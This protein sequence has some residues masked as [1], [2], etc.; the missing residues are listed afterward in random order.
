MLFSLSLPFLLSFQ[1]KTIVIGIVFLAS[2]IPVVIVKSIG[3]IFVWSHC[4]LW[5][6]LSWYLGHFQ[7][8]GGDQWCWEHH[9]RPDG[10]TC[11]GEISKVHAY[12][13]RENYPLLLSALWRNR[14]HQE[15]WDSARRISCQW[16][17]TYR[18]SIRYQSGLTS[19]TLTERS[20]IWRGN[21]C[22]RKRGAVPSLLHPWPSDLRPTDCASRTNWTAANW[23]IR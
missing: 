5:A 7:Q 13:E 20:N 6:Y 4:P 19:S 22:P 10:P 21:Y 3:N 18:K 17:D 23:E 2:V 11:P 12:W 14:S 9:H 1:Y 16:E 15:I 8:E